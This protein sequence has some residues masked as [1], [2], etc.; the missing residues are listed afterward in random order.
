MRTLLLA[1]TLLASPLVAQ[2]R[3]IAVDRFDAAITVHEDGT[4]DVVETM[5]IDFRG[6]WNGIFRE[7]SLAHE[8]ASGRRT[9]LDVDV[10]SVTDVSGQPLEHESRRSGNTRELQIWVPGASDAV[11]TVVVR[12]TVSN[13]LRFFDDDRHMAGGHDE[14]YWNVTGNDWEMPIRSAT[15]RVTLPPGA[16]EVE[17]WA[18]TGPAGSDT[19]DATVERTD[20]EVRVASTRPFAEREGLTVSVAWAPG[21]VDRGAA[22]ARGGQGAGLFARFWPLVVPVFAF[23]LGYRSWSR[24]GREPRRR[25]VVVAYEPPPGLTPA[26]IGTLVDHS[27]ESHDITATLVDLAVRGYVVIEEIRKRRRFGMGQSVEYRFHLRHPPEEWT[28]LAPHEFRYLAGLFGSSET[29]SATIGP[30]RLSPTAVAAAAETTDGASGGGGTATT[31]P[32]LATVELSS[33]TNK[34]YRHMTAIRNAIYD[35]LVE[36]GLYRKRPDRA[37]AGLGFL[38]I[39]LIMGGFFAMI[40]RLND[41]IFVDWRALAVGFVG[42]VFLLFFFAARMKARTEAGVR[43]LEHALG[44]REFLSRVETDRYRRMITSP[45]MFERYLPHAMAFRVER[46][47]A[48][49][50]DDLYTTAP[51]WY[52]GTS[53]TAFRA[54]AFSANLHRMSSTAAQTMSSSPSSSGSGGGGS[55]GGGSGGGGGRGF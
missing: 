5:S 22:L 6:S 39:F 30:V 46:R 37:G 1:L 3:T 29:P 23:L 21:V 13:A 18:Y 27:A 41:E 48:K 53:G 54:S 10:R 19:G 9:R 15:A 25:P 16:R 7:I 43:A 45:E 44:F 51:E 24:H 34:F 55:S 36:R 17:A 49:A 28:D 47:W 14:L 8:T 2:E 40:M 20:G 12:Y 31:A 38:A 33:L 26:E 32:V 52:R 50:F 42:G 4:I 11:R 35:G